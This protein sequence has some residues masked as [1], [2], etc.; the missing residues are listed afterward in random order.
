MIVII[1]RNT[2]FGG[3]D[4]L[5]RGLLKFKI[6]HIRRTFVDYTLNTTKEDVSNER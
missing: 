3:F 4:L 5:L 6:Y 1:P 2:C